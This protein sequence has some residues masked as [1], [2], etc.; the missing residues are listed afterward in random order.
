MNAYFL[1]LATL[2]LSLGGLVFLLG[3]LILRENPRQRLNR[4]VALMMF[5]GGFGSVLTAL[6][7]LAARR[8]TG[9]AASGAV[10]NFSYLWEFFFPALFVFAS[11]FPEER[12]FVRR[13]NH[14]ARRRFI[15]SFDV[16]VYAPHA[17]HFLI[18]LMLVLWHPSFA[19]ARTGALRPFAT[20]VDLAGLFVGLFLAIHQAL[21]SLVNLGFG[22]AA[23]ALLIASFRRARAPRLKQ[24]LP[25]I[26]F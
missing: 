26:A 4:T 22:T 6:S 5:F 18:W 3:L 7:V 8:A 25:V 15:P 9:G 2:N 20:L 19:L 21:F 16:M 23:V 24:Q 12:A 11:V 17:M 10:Q 14:L 13:L 1:P